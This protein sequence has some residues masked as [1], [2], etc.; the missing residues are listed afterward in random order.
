MW[1]SSSDPQKANVVT[2][3]ARYFAK[4]KNPSFNTVT[5]TAR[6]DPWVR[7]GEMW[8]SG[9]AGLPNF[10]RV[11]DCLSSVQF[12]P[13]RSPTLRRLPFF[14]PGVLNAPCMGE[15]LFKKLLRE[16]NI[17]LSSKRN[18]L[19]KK[20]CLTWLWER[21]SKVIQWICSFYWACFLF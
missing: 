10:R 21:G 5:K 20:L 19:V 2:D 13:D 3:V 9:A 12:V 15:K 18:V 8:A 7:W 1:D 17:P 4:F 14:S 6:L 16:E 11:L